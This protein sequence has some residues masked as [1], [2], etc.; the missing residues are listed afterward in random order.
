MYHLKADQCAR[1]A[2]D[3]VDPR[4][5][6]HLENESRLW[7]QIAIAEAR[8]DELRK[9]A[10]DLIVRPV[11]LWAEAKRSVGRAGGW[12]PTFSQ[13]QAAASELAWS[14]YDAAKAHPRILIRG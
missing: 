12:Y 5:R 13:P 2:K 11:G 4:Q 8:Q 10:R 3:S 14:S 6:S 9:K 1:M 7:F